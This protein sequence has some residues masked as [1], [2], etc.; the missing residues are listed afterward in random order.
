MRHSPTASFGLFLAFAAYS[1]AQSA[2]PA[3]PTP[4]VQP[5]PSKPSS[6]ALDLLTRVAQRYR[7]A[8][9]YTIES[10][11][12]H[13]ASAELS[14]SWSK[15][16]LSASE[17][18]GNRSY[19]KGVTETGSAVG[20]SDGKTVWKYRINENRYTSEILS[21]PTS[22]ESNVDT[23]REAGIIYAK[24]L[25]Y[26]LASLAAQLKSAR[27]LPDETLSVN[28]QQLLCRVVEVRSADLEFQDSDYSF[29]RKIWIDA[30]QGIILKTVEHEHR[31]QLPARIP[32]EEETVFL[33]TRTI[34][35]GAIDEGL[36]TFTPPL[37]ARL[38]PEFPDRLESEFPNKTGDP[39]PALKLKS[40]DGKVVDMASFRGKPV[41]LDFWATWC[42][43]CVAALPQI[44]EIYK[45]GKDKGLVLLSVDQDAEAATATHFMTKNGYTWP[46]FHDG[47]G[48]IQNLMGA[49]GIPRLV[50]VDAQ[51][52]IVFDKSGSDENK[53]RAHLVKLG[54]E[55]AGLAPKPK[56]SPCNVGSK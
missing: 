56:P 20:I 13:T 46:N 54:P 47:D 27:R 38:V 34:L 39:V 31:I 26:G 3:S 17:A 40:A 10:V 44:A 36:F 29:D 18:P 11:E 8:K 16:F 55:Y 42:E 6:E 50:L 41:L 28:G 48:E 2:T 5:A 33:Y 53:L 14:H 37:G 49:S 51:G 32:L 24:Q 21:S 15:M 52:T 4:D 19:F 23:S 12:E 30:D 43:P 9:S 45:E 22:A 35:D 7:D 25:R 1:F